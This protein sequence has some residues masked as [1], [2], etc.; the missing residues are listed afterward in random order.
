MASERQNQGGGVLTTLGGLIQREQDANLLYSYH[1]TQAANY[2][3]DSDAKPYCGDPLELDSRPT[4]TSASGNCSVFRVGGDAELWFLGIGRPATGTFSVKIFG[5]RLWQ[6][7][8]QFVTDRREP[9]PLVWDRKLLVSATITLG[10]KRAGPTRAELIT[11]GL[12]PDLGAILSDVDVCA[13][14]VS[15]VTDLTNPV[16]GAMVVQKAVA[17]N[18]EAY[19]VFNP[20]GFPIL[21]VYTSIN[22]GSATHHNGVLFGL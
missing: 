13:S 17:D 16:P 1:S 3:A 10:T 18:T 22:S 7:H 8:T 5:R 9:R 20:A 14:A 12:D 6:C 21:E 4:L 11:A 19:L 2:P 15:I